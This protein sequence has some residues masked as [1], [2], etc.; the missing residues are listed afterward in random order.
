MNHWYKFVSLVFPLL[1]L[2]LLAFQFNVRES[3]NSPMKGM[4]TMV[5][6]G[7]HEDA[8]VSSLLINED[9][10]NSKS[11]RPLEEN[12]HAPQTKR[13]VLVIG[14]TAGSVR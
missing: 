9:R 11:A 4:T 3:E 8:L 2:G 7:T 12:L 10:R 6:I 13:P 1:A 14:G 5:Q